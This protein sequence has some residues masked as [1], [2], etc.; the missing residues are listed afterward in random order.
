MAIEKNID[1]NKCNPL[2][3]EKQEANP[4]TT[5][6]TSGIGGSIMNECVPLYNEAFGEWVKKGENNS[7]IVL[8]RDRPSHE[9][10]GYGGLGDTGAGSIDLVVGREFVAPGVPV[11]PNFKTDSA[12]I[13]ISQ[14]TD[15]DTNFGLPAGSNHSVAESAITIKADA[16]RVVGR[17]S[18]KVVAGAGEDSQNYGVDVIAN[19]DDSGLQP[20]VKGDNLVAAMTQLIKDTQALMGVVQAYGMAQDQWNAVMV[21]MVKY[22]P[23]YG[24]LTLPQQHH[25]EEGIKTLNKHAQDFHEGVAKHD[26]QVQKF[27][28][29]YI[30][31]NSKYYINSSNN[32]VN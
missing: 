5:L 4:N 2:A 26:V 9:G 15:S 19:N 3:D 30:K 25:V 28:D 11:N 7:F 23:F 10:S 17:R 32:K 22:S 31:P 13:H 8:G 21:T 29:T 12:R 14:K 1:N 24:A 16:V 18:I 20:M 27:K 6:A